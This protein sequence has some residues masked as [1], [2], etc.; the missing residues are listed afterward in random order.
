MVVTWFI[1]FLVLLV[2]ELVTINLVS[3]WFAVGALSS[4]ISACFTENITIQVIIFI[5]VSIIALLITKPFVEKLRKR[6]IQPTNL[7]RV[8]GSEGVVTKEIDKNS[9]GEVKVKGSVWTAMS[10]TKIEKGKEIKVLKIE[11]V[12]LLVEEIEEDK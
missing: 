12:K 3:I 8:I 5:I 2:I 11:G 1:V 10:D 6:K 7:D 9:Y 4:M